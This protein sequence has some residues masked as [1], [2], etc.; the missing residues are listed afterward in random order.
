M[1]KLFYF[2]REEYPTGFFVVLVVKGDDRDCGGSQIPS[3]SG[4]KTVSL[5]IEP[6][7]TKKDYIFAS[8]IAL[9][10]VIGFCIFYIIGMIAVKI[11]DGRQ[12]RAQL[13]TDEDRL[14]EPYSIAGPSPMGEVI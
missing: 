10:A 8:S 2:Q 9:S 5:S 3:Y 4:N 12:L 14:E 6:S 11:R 7:I 13:L 1:E